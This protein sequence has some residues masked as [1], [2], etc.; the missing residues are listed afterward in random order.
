MAPSL[1][2]PELARLFRRYGWTQPDDEFVA[3]TI[4]E[5]TDRGYYLNDLSRQIFRELAGFEIAV[6]EVLAQ[7]IS[8]D[9]RTD[10]YRQSN[11]FDEVYEFFGRPMSPVAAVFA[12]NG[13]LWCDDGFF[14]TFWPGEILRA[15]DDLSTA[16]DNIIFH[17]ERLVEI[18]EI[19]DHYADD[20]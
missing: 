14:V 11:E 15:G 3:A 8:F 6:I 12:S 7:D 19:A 10:F 1:L 16:L 20:D 4:S 9:A 13:Y 5:L 17:N 2:S 18:G